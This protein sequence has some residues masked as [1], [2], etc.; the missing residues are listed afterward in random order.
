MI[1]RDL[2]PDNVGFTHDHI[3]KLFDFGLARELKPE[4]RMGRDQFFLS[5]AGSPRYMAPEVMRLKP[6]GLPADVFSLSILLYEMSHLKKPFRSLN[7]KE[8][9]KAILTWRKRP[10]LSKQIPKDL[11]KLM[12]KCWKHHANERPDMSDCY[13]ALGSFL[14][15][16]QI[17]IENS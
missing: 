15:L 16:N 14:E 3:I 5:R 4:R 17:S 6:Y 1:F 9:E 7:A 11:R 8:H 10:K 13:R 12:K 2:K